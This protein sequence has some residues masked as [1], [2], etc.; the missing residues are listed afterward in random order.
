[1]STDLNTKLVGIAQSAVQ[2]QR[3]ARAKRSTGA[4]ALDAI[5]NTSYA[6]E[7]QKA[8]DA[9]LRKFENEQWKPKMQKHLTSELSKMG[10]K[11]G[12]KGYQE[13]YDYL[14]NQNYKKLQSA[15]GQAQQKL[16]TLRTKGQ[17]QRQ[18]DDKYRNRE[19]VRNNNAGLQGAAHIAR[20]TA[21]EVMGGLATGFSRTGRAIVQTAADVGEN[22][23][24]GMF[25]RS[26][27][28]MKA[29]EDNL[30]K[31]YPSYSDTQQNGTFAQKVALGAVENIP[32]I[33]ALG[34]A[35]GAAGKTAQLLGAGQ[36]GSALAAYGASSASIYPMAYLDGNDSIKDE[37]AAVTPD[38]LK[39]SDVSKDIYSEHFN[40]N[41]QE[42]LDE[43]TATAKARDQTVSKLAEIGGNKVGLATI[44]TSLIAPGVGSQVAQRVGGGT[45]TNIGSKA[46]NRLAVRADSGKVARIAIPA[47]AVGV[48]AGLNAVEEG[49]QEGYTD[50]VAQ[51]TAV[52]VGVKNKIDQAQNN[53]AVLLGATLGGLFGGGMSIAGSSR[54]KTAQAQLG[55]VQDQYAQ[56][57]QQ[58]ID[59]RAALEE[60]QA[61]TPEFEQASTAL[62]Q[63][64]QG[65]SAMKA[66]A[67][68]VGIP[69][70]SLSRRAPRVDPT[71]ANID[72]IDS[73]EDATPPMGDSGQTDQVPPEQAG[74]P[75]PDQVPPAEDAT[76]AMS[77]KERDAQ[78]AQI[79]DLIAEQNLIDEAIQDGSNERTVEESIEAANNWYAEKRGDNKTGL[80]GVVARA[81]TAEQDEAVEQGKGLIAQNRTSINDYIADQR[82][83]QAG[84]D[85]QT[86][87]AI[88]QAE[89]PEQGIA[90]AAQREAKREQE[91]ELLGARE[92]LAQPYDTDTKDWTV[93][94][95]DGAPFNL[96]RM[97][98]ERM[99]PAQRANAIDTASNGDLDQN[100]AR[101]D[102]Q[103]IPDGIKTVLHNFMT[104]GLGK[105]R[106]AIKTTQAE[107]QATAPVADMPS[108]SLSFRDSIAAPVALSQIEPTADASLTQASPA[109]PLDVDGPIEL[110]EQNP[111]INIPAPGQNAKPVAP[112]ET[113]VAKTLPDGVY[114]SQPAARAAMRK[115]KL[116]PDAVN[117]VARD[118]GFALD[119]I[120]PTYA[121]A[122]AQAAKELNMTLDENGE[123]EGTDEEF[124]AFATRVDEI[125]G[126]AL[127]P[128]N[129]SAGNPDSNVTQ[130][131]K[132]TGISLPTDNESIQEYVDNLGVNGEPT[133]NYQQRAKEITE[134]LNKKTRAAI[135]KAK[136]ERGVGE[137][138]APKTPKNNGRTLG[139]YGRPTDGKP[140]MPGDVFQTAS[141]RDTTPYPKQKSSKF[142]SQWLIDNAV[143]EAEA[144]GNKF[145]ARN[146][147]NTDI[148]KGGAL[149]QA[150]QE[151][152][153]QYLS[154]PKSLA[155][156][157]KKI[158][159]KPVK[160]AP[161]G[162]AMRTT[163]II[164]N[165][166]VKTKSFTPDGST[167]VNSEWD[168]VEAADLVTSHTDAFNVNP[169]YPADG[170][171]PR[172][173]SR[174]KYRDQVIGIAQK[175]N[176][177]IL[178][179]SPNVSE[180]SPVIGFDDNIVE[181][182][183]GR[184]MSIRRAYQNKEDENGKA[185]GYKQYVV[186]QAAS[187]GL[188]PDAVRSMTSP[189]LV[190]RRTPEM[191]RVKFAQATSVPG[192]SEMSPTE[193]AAMDA[194][195]LPNA[196]NI[197][198]NSKGEMSLPMSRTFVNQFVDGLADTERNAVLNENN[199][200]SPDGEV[201]VRRAIL[202]GVYKSDK[203]VSA[204]AED[205]DS[206]A[207]TILKAITE[208]APKIAVLQQDV[209]EGAA[210]ENTLAEDIKAA[211]EKYIDLQAS[212]TTVDQYL[213]E[214]NLFGDGISEGAETILKEFADNKQSGVKI[215]QA[216]ED[217]I[218]II[219]NQPSP[220][221]EVLF[222]RK[223]KAQE[224]KETEAVR[225]QHE[226]K[227][228]WMKAPNGNDT[229]LNEQQWLQVRTPAFKEWF[230]DWETDPDN[231]SKVVDANG[232]PKVVHH[233]TNKDFT[234]FDINRF[235]STDSGW[236]GKGFYFHSD[237]DLLGYGNKL[238]SAFLNIRS[239]IDVNSD[240]MQDNYSDIF[241][242]N[243]NDS[244]KEKSFM[245]N[246]KEM[247]SADFTDAAKLKGYDGTI[248]NYA[249]GTSELVAFDANQIK[250]ATD[251]TGTFDA[252]NND[253][254]YSKKSGKETDAGPKDL[255]V[256]HN[257]TSRGILAATELGGLAAPSIAVIRAGVSD[258][259]GYG[260]ITLLA[261]PNL[262]NAKDM[263]TFDAD[264][265]SPRQP[266]AQHN[267]NAKR[268]RDFENTLEGTKLDLRAPDLSSMEYA[269]GESDFVRSP[270]V[271]YHF[272]QSI[273][274]TPKLKPLK[275]DPTTK[276]VAKL[277]KSESGRVIDNPK[278]APLARKYANKKLEQSLTMS[279]ARNERNGDDI[280]KGADV[281]RSVYF[282]EDG[283]VNKD[284]AYKLID[285]ALKYNK[286]DGKDV[287][288]LRYDIDV[289]LR[290]DKINKA[291]ESW[292]MAEFNKLSDGQRMRAGETKDGTR[293][294]KPY[295][296]DNVV[297][298][299]TKSLNGGENFNY[300][301]GSVR[302]VFANKL[303]DTDAI[304]ASREKIIS[305][306]D[307][308]AVK[309]ES[310]DKYSEALDKLKPF[311]A[312]DSDSYNYQDDVADAIIKG[313]KA[314]RE[315]FGTNKEALKIIADLKTYL[316]GLP[317]EYFEAKAQRA[318]QF[319]EFDTAIVPKNAD[320][321][322]VQA[323]KD[324]GVKIKRYDQKVEGD[325]YRVLAEQKKL[326]FSRGQK[327]KT[328]KGATN[329]TQAQVIEV[330]QQRFGK[331]VVAKLIKSGKLRIRTLSDFTDGRGNLL[332]P[333]DAEGMYYDNKATLIADNL[334]ADSAVAVLLH[335]LGGHAGIQDMLSPAEYAK[336]MK[337][338]DRL[339]ESGN[340]IAVRAKA[341][342]EANTDTQEQASME[343]IPYLIT[344][345]SAATQSDSAIKK[346][347]ARV[348]AAIR[349]WA[350]TN[351]G[352]NIRVTPND[353][354][355]LAERMIKRIAKQEDAIARLETTADYVPF[356]PVDDVTPQSEVDAV[357]KQYQDTDQWMKAPDGS[358]TKLN[359]QQWLQVRT[360]S[361]K[362][363]F[364]DWGGDP[365]NASKILDENGEPMVVYHG[366]SAKDIAVFRDSPQTNGLLF[367]T[368]NKGDA[369]SYSNGEKSGYMDMEYAEDKAN[370][371]IA[372]GYL[373]ENG[374]SDM[375]NGALL[376]KNIS[377]ETK[378]SEFAGDSNI[379]LVEA[380]GDKLRSGKVSL[381]GAIDEINAFISSLYREGKVYG[382]F[383]NVTKPYSSKTNPISWQEAEKMGSNKLSD[384]S[385]GVFV[386]EDDSD[387]A[388]AVYNPNQIKSATDNTGA[389]DASNN[390]IR[391]SRRYS[392]AAQGLPNSTPKQ[393]AANKVRLGA[394]AAMSANTGVIRLLRRHIATPQHVALLNPSFKT[395]TDNVQARLAYENNE[396]GKVQVH[397]PEIWD[398]KLLVGKRKK[399]IERV[400][401][402]LFDGTMADVVWRD[403]QLTAD[404]N[405]S[406]DDIKLY[407]RMRTSINESLKNMTNDTLSS[408]AKGTK[409]TNIHTINAM[410]LQDMDPIFQNI[411]LQAHMTAELQRLDRGGLI[412]PAAVVRIQSQLDEVF[413][414]MDSIALKFEDLVDRG[415]A[416]LMRFGNY[417]VE[418]REKATGKLDL[419][420]LYEGNDVTGP[421]AQWKAIKD[422]EKKY[423]TDLYEISKG[424]LNPEAFKQFSDKGL[425]P[426]TVQLFASELGL[427][428]DGAVQAYL[429]V[430]VS[431]RSAL[432]RMIHRKKVPGYSEDMPRVVS[433]FVMS[434]ARHSG[435]MLYNG[436]IENSIQK[437]KDGD[438]QGEAQNVFKNMEDPQEEYAGI[439]NT[440]FHW[441]MAFSPA[442]LF[443]NLTQPFT[444]TI[445]KLTAYSG[446]G[447]A[448]KDIAQALAHVAAYSG[449][450]TWNATK[451]A[452]GK[453]D[454]NWE[455]FEDHLPSWVR[456]DDYLKM[457]REGHLDPQ[458][459]W[460]IRGLERGKTG[461]A[462]GV[463]GGFEA[464][465]GWP[466]EVSEGINR[467]STMIA[468]FKTAERMGDTKLK[469]KG[470]DN[471]Y[472]FAVSVIQQTQGIY[473]KGNRSGLARGTGK[474]GQ[475]GP[476]V[477]VFK[478]FV[479][480]Y[481]EQMIRHGR[482]KEIGSLLV[483]MSWQMGLAGVFGLPFV[484]DLRDLI[485]GLLFRVFGKG[486]NMTEYLKSVMGEENANMFMYGVA[487]E[488]TA[489]DFY[490]RSSMGNLLPLTDFTRPGEGDWGEVI[491]AS[492]SFFENFYTGA[493]YVADGRYRDAVTVASP[494]Y[495]KDALNG[496]EIWNTGA[497]RNHRG[498]KVMDMSKTDAVIKGL[499]QFNPSSNAKQGRERS[500]LYHM[501]N[502]I[503]ENHRKY[504]LMLAEAIYQEDDEMVD[505]AYYEM[506][507]WNNKNTDVYQIDIEKVEKSADNRVKNK[508]FDSEERNEKSL[509]T[510]LKSND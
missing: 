69:F 278:F 51:K 420:E 484:D 214:G 201:R 56:G 237:T 106:E 367:F 206:N 368:E 213:E 219:R 102:W 283:S 282:D 211:A 423:D 251:N 156:D 441:F 27:K 489:I 100:L 292:A 76:P 492:S 485:E 363:W 93:T 308:E 16:G 64:Q 227:A 20:D 304:K 396:A 179:Y 52:D 356:D 261:D 314:I 122:E 258:F 477:M 30:Q 23:D 9:A 1:M 335:E 341:R 24:G 458:N 119:P 230:G 326:L 40:K 394:A 373:V 318:V 110:T 10:H 434:N 205:G 133:V 469:E 475:F 149:L 323:L 96:G 426:E 270:A 226:G 382:V 5:T 353:I 427:D 466:A 464:L 91:N 365:D 82:A 17:T 412:T 231:A 408:L 402:A 290:N 336:L 296:L 269:G 77:D 463:W 57:V 68:K 400:S 450:A 72:D 66:E 279:R 260:E 28:A 431:D 54:I 457:S 414:V 174:G 3:A 501:K 479:I 202:R 35:A 84:I 39:G 254:R 302:S 147:R 154:D 491:G 471:A 267:I 452:V 274:K 377:D 411:S 249:Q 43:T 320:P 123:Y 465:A 108:N 180:G 440:M 60:A 79:A 218:N 188:D 31:I 80:S 19:A 90:I 425:S 337:E 399:S 8:A 94:G 451:E 347:I 358:D 21:E 143:A 124:E 241:F 172:D 160:T 392:N 416:P 117:V 271:K 472:D 387:A 352:L 221:Q 297:N 362:Q 357:R 494:R 453:G 257:I 319:N 500:E 289:V 159:P 171:Q 176:P 235:G 173:R 505:K 207:K 191:D 245:L 255:L 384:S 415:Y 239:P 222:S 83:Q 29:G 169:D 232:E 366:S 504:S 421:L 182:G 407:K 153:Q 359:E 329:T 32:Q 499:G 183:N 134:D 303:L 266:R 345:Q 346:F 445:P 18:L 109:Q 391:F 228:T 151:G 75:Q 372:R 200:L 127:K 33:I 508:D 103:S 486:F 12:S 11:P 287:N 375:F 186:K 338:F 92:A 410:K 67:E 25:D 398:T 327:P 422:L 14:F 88:E 435:R 428:S 65:L 456:K 401:R 168:V 44:L 252:S 158:A 488:K 184:S 256:A 131:T 107:E 351:L 63:T 89:T 298:E 190:R 238:V 439:R 34:G 307:F 225:K 406:P 476:L 177:E 181:S 62:L 47:A 437:I 409:L 145:A 310:S 294:Y 480:N 253:I 460:M 468:A 74:Q 248:L 236:W 395:F 135:A 112:V 216:L 386:T 315:I 495:V 262:L 87:Q 430:A 316:A 417:A 81:K 447:R 104:D 178:A 380:I 49:A 192:I 42:G 189:V 166:K 496:I 280:N 132:K 276:A 403:D 295:T 215:K 165:E 224:V 136:A 163:P 413:K 432:K 328:V 36:K 361:F 61:G 246:V 161:K 429:K 164:D 121:Q 97:W 22:D 208:I 478:Q 467:R 438:L 85:A 146:F 379:G 424:T 247:G 129:K 116:K 301:P 370:L 37:L 293:K 389:F 342:A 462:S 155:A 265:Y 113:P 322:A 503:K 7:D 364:G 507:E 187:L 105:Q 199:T 273:G 285:Q 157:P 442:F 71:T 371:D 448:H 502:M 101:A 175:L 483:A 309:K 142:A 26:A 330:L 125:Q 369:V 299:M 263:P 404:F 497:Y 381:S 99:T 50:Y 473:N 344:E 95:A 449:K 242:S 306:E 210:N 115:L 250:S 291:Y 150:D 233:R 196:A 509:P 229:N 268:F 234:E 217:R 419:F 333:E 436:E 138:P 13:K 350:R 325:R 461:I 114:K 376:S 383:L 197:K 313:D 324:A 482:D 148:Q 141:G 481:S 498:D 167:T 321:A 355:H 272:L 446:A 139:E 243:L 98:N 70:S 58:S 300:G 374:D 128:S 137:K 360:P 490:G 78:D 354:T 45:L 209:K 15:K 203:L 455:G 41:I 470:F 388:I 194:S 220:N 111:V 281:I 140:V 55:Q 506:E 418:V 493:K 126:R 397:V 86:Q 443:L 277:I 259:T 264:I 311:Y 152:M 487:S 198:F 193:I 2:A 348:A 244:F 284:T 331:D 340:E 454:P 144:R 339:V 444:Q 73:T 48:V 185:A 288:D 118:G 390:D 385:D 38:Q 46:F 275:A 474:L 349:S 405:L 459:V 305:K 334:D 240:Y 195:K 343:Y 223:A 120:P 4:K 59:Q 393:K 286:H 170:L 162:G 204:F 130:E 6:K 510:S 312:F 433:A 332:V 317:T 378:V 53:E 212:D